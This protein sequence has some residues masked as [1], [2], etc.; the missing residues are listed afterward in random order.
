MKKAKLELRVA[1]LESHNATLQTR[2]TEL[3]TKYW[4]CV[5]ELETRL[6]L[7]CNDVREM[8]ASHR[9][10][11]ERLQTQCAEA[12]DQR[13]AAEAKLNA[14]RETHDDA[15][16]KIVRLHDELF[17]ARAARA[18]AEAPGALTGFS[19]G[20]TERPPAEEK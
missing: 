8:R 3:L 5:A 1:E 15:G 7:Y 14:L 18:L 9:D 6:R 17:V 20:D 2:N 16:A 19:E 10:T 4:G 11:V 13:D 12:A